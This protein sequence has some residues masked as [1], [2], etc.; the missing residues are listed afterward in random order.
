M[1]GEGVSVNDGI[2]GGRRVVVLVFGE[3]EVGLV[4]SDEMPFSSLEELFL[5]PSQPRLHDFP[6][7]F[8]SA[9]ASAS[10]SASLTPANPTST[11]IV[12]DSA[13]VLIPSLELVELAELNAEFDLEDIGVVGSISSEFAE[14]RDASDGAVIARMM[15]GGRLGT[16]GKSS[17]IPN[18]LFFLVKYPRSVFLPRDFG[19]LGGSEIVGGLPVVSI[20]LLLILVTG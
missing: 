6:L 8:F 20:L 13:G 1:D 7:P 9:S 2:V 4:E 16:G 15:G 14:E 10:A 5:V 3:I 17:S 12:R 19:V 11:P 18:E